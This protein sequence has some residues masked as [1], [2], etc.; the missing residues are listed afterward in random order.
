VFCEVKHVQPGVSE[1]HLNHKDRK[2]KDKKLKKLYTT[3]STSTTLLLQCALLSF[4]HDSYLWVL[5]LH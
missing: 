3:R 5:L 2:K 1:N 4:Q